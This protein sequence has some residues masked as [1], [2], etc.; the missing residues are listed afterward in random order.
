MT[1]ASLA[2]GPGAFIQ[3][4]I[5]YRKTLN[6]DIKKDKLFGVTIH[7]EKGNYIE[8]GKQFMSYYDKNYPKMLDFLKEIQTTCL[9]I[10][11]LIQLILHFLMGGIVLKQRWT[12]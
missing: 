7:P 4:V 11:I 8:M 10:L 1:V 6:F 9:K 5:Q 12:I 2:E 3:A